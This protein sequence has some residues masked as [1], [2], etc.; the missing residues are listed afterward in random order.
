MDIVDSQVHLGP[1]GASEMIAAMDALG[2]RSVLLDEYWLGTPGHPSYR[3]G[4]G[5]LR[6]SSPTAE[7]ASWTFPGR[8]SYIVRVDRQD[9]ELK[10]VARIVRD[11][12][13]ARA[14]R[15]LVGTNRTETAAFAAGGYDHVFAAAADCGLPLFVAISGNAQL[16]TRYLEKFPEVKVIVDHCGM[17]PSR[18]VRGAIAKMEGLPDSEEYW[19]RFGAVPLRESLQ[20]VLSL[21][22]YPNVALKWAHSSAI[23]EDPAY[24]NQSV[25]PF[26]R[27]VLSAF[28]ASRV[29]WASDISTLATGETWA[30]VLFSVIGNSDLSTADREDLLGR[31][32]RHWLDWEYEGAALES[33]VQS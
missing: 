15:I 4:S 10:S 27:D 29:M 19:S 13:F 11:A 26:L 1:G 12:R 14:L 32:A 21:A 5:G 31:T 25:R 22:T 6:T 30:Q 8:F 7:L 33:S 18:L 16:L 17:P 3:V 2:I 23:F 20:K 9:P 24:P 28:G